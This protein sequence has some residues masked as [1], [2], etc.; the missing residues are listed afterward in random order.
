MRKILLGTAV[1]FAAACA[2]AQPSLSPGAPKLLIVISVD[3]LSSD[4]W[5]EYRPQ[6]TGGLARLAQGTVFRNGYQSHAATET[7]PG[8]STILTGVRP[9]RN[10]IVANVWFDAKAPRTDKT[11]YCAEDETVPGTNSTKYQVSPAHLRVPTLGDLLKQRSPASMNVA[12]AGKDRSAVMMS[13]RAVDQRWYPSGTSFA[14]DLAS[15]PVPQSVT[16]TNAEMTRVLALSRE[17]LEPT[18]FCAA[19]SQV[20]PIEGGGKPV[21]NGRFARAAGDAAAFRAS[22]EAD[23]LA[24]ALSAALVQEMALGRDAAPDILSIGLAGTDYVGH[25]Y[26]TGGQEMCLQLLSLDRDL[27]DFFARLDSWGIDYAVALTADHGGLD[28]PE[29]L[30]AKGVAG[31]AWIDRALT[32]ERLG[33]QIAAATRL[34]GPIIVSGGPSGDIFLDP[35]L[36]AA[37][38]QRALDALLAAYRA[39]PQVQAVFTKDEIVRT[40]LPGDDP[41]GWTSIQRVRASFDAE[42]SGDLYVVL[43]PHIQPIADTSRYVATHGSPW[44]YDRRVPVLFWRPGMA[45]SARDEPVETVDMMPTLAAALSVPVAPG[46]VDGRCLAGV[47][48]IA[49]SGVVARPERGQR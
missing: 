17:P 34:N 18:P 21:G 4:L 15:A 8:H 16:R 20:F 45:S 27:G 10:G 48:G 28:I 30:R 32:T 40:P 3:Q 25:T 14:T 5:D 12:V 38:R 7:C 1:A 11:I 24:L 31:A 29:R 13:G 36:A 33:Q 6:F 42:R 22:P 37:D 47:P 2:Q 41:V 19:K 44:D 39:H 46:S 26:G 9:A 49:C 35:A 43:K 23:A